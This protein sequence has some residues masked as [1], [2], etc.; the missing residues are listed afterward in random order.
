MAYVRTVAMKSA[1]VTVS[2][3]IPTY[4]GLSLL[5]KNLS[6]V[7]NAL[8]EGDQLIVV[9]D[10]GTDETVS[11]FCQE[12]ALDQQPSQDVTFNVWSGTLKKVEII[13]IQNTEN[14]RF[15][16][17]CNR[18]ATVATKDV[19]WLLNNDVQP[20]P[21]ARTHAVPLF[22]DAS[23]FAVGCKEVQGMTEK[24]AGKGK[25]WFEKGLF[26]HAKAEPLTS[27]ECDWVNGGSSFFSREKW[28][29]LHGFDLAFYPAYWEDIDL[30][31]R[32]SKQ[33]WKVVFDDQAVVHHLH[34]TTNQS[35]F[36][37]RKIDAMSWK[38]GLT[39]TWKNSNLWQKC[40]FLVWQPYWWRKRA[41]YL[42]QLATGVH[43]E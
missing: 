9:D 25:L 15:A 26:H 22:S 32:A 16:A 33:G 27:G 14:L 28:G 13:L 34:E 7:L 11:W 41:R 43:H 8:K 20:T 37:Q 1:P 29:K 39:F 6:S 10:A 42:S 19:L 18:A 30:C 21:S 12:Y 5:Q 31:F 35:V 36:G 17:S 3:I 40:L 38:N 24:A 4:N 2:A 23:I